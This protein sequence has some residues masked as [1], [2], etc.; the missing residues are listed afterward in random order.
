MDELDSELGCE[1][2]RDDGT[3][4]ITVPPDTGDRHALRSCPRQSNDKNENVDGVAEI[5][6]Q[7]Q[8]KIPRTGSPSGARLRL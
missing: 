8:V 5:P 3:P 4:P 7:P 6:S 2:L 1:R